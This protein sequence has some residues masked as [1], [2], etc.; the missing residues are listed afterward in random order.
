MEPITFTQQE[1]ALMIASAVA[2]RDEKWNR[3]IGYGVSSL[4]LSP[5]EARGW[6]EKDRASRARNVAEARLWRG[7]VRW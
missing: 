7:P 1:V 3:A 5:E 6:L 2:A 4:V